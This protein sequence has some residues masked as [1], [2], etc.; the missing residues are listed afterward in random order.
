MTKFINSLGFN[1]SIAT[2]EQIE[3]VQQ[4]ISKKE[5]DLIKNQGLYETDKYIVVGIDCNI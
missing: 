4:E 5:L 2:N 1:F 3:E